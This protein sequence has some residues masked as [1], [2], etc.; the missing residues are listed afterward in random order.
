MF[1]ALT[2]FCG[3]TK[4]AFKTRKTMR[5]KPCCFA[6]MRRITGFVAQYEKY[7]KFELKTREALQRTVPYNTEVRK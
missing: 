5:P 4:N 6:L 7:F 1:Q 3:P 2:S